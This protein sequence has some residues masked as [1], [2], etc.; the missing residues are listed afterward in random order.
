MPRIILSASRRSDIPAFYMPWF[1]QQIEQGFFV[2]DNPYSG[3]ITTVPATNT[4]VHSIVFWSKDFGP[5]LIGGYG[6]RLRRQGFGLFFNFTLNSPHSLLEPALPPLD[7]RLAQLAQ[8]C[9][10]F[11]PQTVQWRFDPLCFF[12]NG[13]GEEENNLAGFSVIAEQAALLK[14]PVCITSFADP[15]RK[16]LRRFK[17]AGIAPIEPVLQTKVALIARLAQTLAGSGIELQLCC[18]KE[19][20]N[21]LPQPPPA[22][23]A[24]CIPGAR[25]ACLYGGDLSLK[26]D[27]SQRAAA[28]CGCTVSKDIG[29][30]RNHP[31]PHNCLYCYAA[32]LVDRRAVPRQ[33]GPA[34]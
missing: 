26:R 14:V 5:F 22:G 18:E 29:S 13:R 32:P 25:L 12:R 11:G 31:C 3:K 21:A 10:V 24:A 6:E 1:M 33:E 28:G 15:Y 8:L 9:T 30:Y 34:R 20:L 16:V 2:V 27:R 7:Q 19:V 17:K 4:Q 23:Q